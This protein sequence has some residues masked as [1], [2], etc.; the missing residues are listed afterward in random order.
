MKGAGPFVVWSRKRRVLTPARQST[1]RMVME[2]STSLPVRVKGWEELT[3]RMSSSSALTT[4]LR[5]NV[6]E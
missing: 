6:A 2:A 3:L 4:A 5:S 1:L